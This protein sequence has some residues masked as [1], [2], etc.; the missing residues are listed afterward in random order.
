MA[1]LDDALAELNEAT[2]SV[3]ARLEDVLDDIEQA[4]SNAAGKVRAEVARL[5]DLAADPANPVPPEQP[6]PQVS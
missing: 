6:Q 1:Q 4:D 2:N 3:A 5:R